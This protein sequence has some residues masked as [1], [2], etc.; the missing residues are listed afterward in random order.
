MIK[1]PTVS[2]V[3]G[4]NVI[5]LHLGNIIDAK[6]LIANTYLLIS[7]MNK[8]GFIWRYDV[9][10]IVGLINRSAPD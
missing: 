9:K 1:I 7:W 6:I 5:I 3:D 8:V 10:S 2:S 4:D